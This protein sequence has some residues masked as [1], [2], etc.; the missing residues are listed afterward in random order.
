MIPLMVEFATRKLALEALSRLVIRTPV[1]TGRARANWNLSLNTP[2]DSFSMSDV[3]PGGGATI[4]A[5]FSTLLQLAPFELVWITNNLPYIEFLEDGGSG[6]APEG[7]VAVTVAELESE[8][9][10]FGD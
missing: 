8:F 1:L 10:S 3:D 6:Q 4:D 7:M 9:G 5:G 2:D